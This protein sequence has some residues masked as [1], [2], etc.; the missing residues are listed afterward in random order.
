MLAAMTDEK[1]RL[2]RRCLKALLFITYNVFLALAI[3]HHLSGGGSFGSDIGWCDGLGFV[4]AATAVVYVCVVVSYGRRKLPPSAALTNARAKVV[5]A[6]SN[7]YIKIAIYALCLIA[8]AVFIAVDTA[9][10]RA[11]AISASGIVAIIML[12]A[13]LSKHPRLAFYVLLRWKSYEKKHFS[14]SRS[15]DWRQVVTGLILQYVFGLIVLR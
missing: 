9:G 13:L 4:L 14:L 1:R 12:G 6:A 11:R 8:I 3:G 10:N 5:S 15:I 2:L 7:R